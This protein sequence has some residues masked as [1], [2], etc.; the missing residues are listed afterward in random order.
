M[1]VCPRIPVPLLSQAVVSIDDS[2]ISR[3]FVD[4]DDKACGDDGSNACARRAM[5]DDDD[6]I[7][8]SL[9]IGDGLGIEDMLMDNDGLESMMRVGAGDEHFDPMASAPP[10]PP[11]TP[12]RR[13]S[14]WMLDPIEL[15]FLEPSV[16]SAYRTMVIGDVTHQSV[17]FNFA[18]IGMNVAA[19]CG[20]FANLGEPCT[21]FYPRLIP[22]QMSMIGISGV[23]IKDT[24]LGKSLR[25]TLA[26]ASEEEFVVR[27]MQQATVL[28]PACRPLPQLAI[29][30]PRPSYLSPQAVVSLITH[31]TGWL[32]ELASFR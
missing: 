23:L 29:A 21:R 9:A 20:N 3:A 24:I 16:E 18:V 26:K 27:R 15:V 5:E 11:C 6:G 17:W 13:A 2:W 10:S 28:A 25:K 14:D 12:C 19:L 31:S 1:H 32:H 22:L 8:C 30:M 4:E 7:W